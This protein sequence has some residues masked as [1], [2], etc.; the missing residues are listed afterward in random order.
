MEYNE[1]KFV[2][3][4]STSLAALN[5]VSLYF[6]Y[7]DR[8]LD[9]FLPNLAKN[10]SRDSFGNRRVDSSV[11]NWANDSSTGDKTVSIDFNTS[12]TQNWHEH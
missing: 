9:S 11:G 8:Y 6:F 2:V 10:S 3:L 5:F 12:K 4:L 1:L 7:V